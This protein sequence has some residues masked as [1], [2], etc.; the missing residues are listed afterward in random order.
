MEQLCPAS[1]KE[2][3]YVCALWGQ[4]GCLMNQ[5]GRATLILYQTEPLHKR[6]ALVGLANIVDLPSFLVAKSGQ[7]GLRPHSWI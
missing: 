4:R 5:T 7:C 3:V 6:L 1:R 2:T